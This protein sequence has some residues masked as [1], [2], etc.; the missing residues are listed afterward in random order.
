MVTAKTIS[1]RGLFDIHQ[2]GDKYYFEI[3]DAIIGRELLLTTWLV[4]VPGG[5]PKF[6]G[7]VLNTKTIAFSKER[8]NKIG[9]KIIT[10][11]SQSD[12]ANVISRAVRN[13]NVDAVAFVFDVKARGAESK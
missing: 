11:V 2:N 4:K 7:E 1:K 12:T 8:G 6:G 5:S 9:L 3:P 10:T 13:S